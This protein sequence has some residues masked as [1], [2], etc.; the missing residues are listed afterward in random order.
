M[1]ELR[2][3]SVMAHGGLGFG[4]VGDV[5]CFGAGGNDIGVE[6]SELISLALL[7]CAVVGID[8]ASDGCPVELHPTVFLFIG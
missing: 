6:A 3:A 4:Y 5:G 7:P 2:F 1:V 8:Q